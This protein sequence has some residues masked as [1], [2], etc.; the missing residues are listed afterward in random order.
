MITRRDALAYLL[1]PF[2]QGRKAATRL[3]VSSNRRYLQTA[4]GTPLFLV[5]DCPQNMPLKLAISELEDFMADC[6]AKGFNVL[7]ICM[8][9]Q[10]SGKL[11]TRPPIDRN[12]NLMMKSGWDISTLNEAYFATIDAIAKSA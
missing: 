2:A 10:E 9:G 12:H 3:S 6:E 7:W 5:G 1:A 4:S 11:A 8:D